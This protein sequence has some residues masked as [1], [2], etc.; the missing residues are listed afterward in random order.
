MKY[1]TNDKY[2]EQI[3]SEDKAYF[4]GLLF[5]DGYNFIGKSY[6]VTLQ[7]CIGDIDILK[8]FRSYIGDCTIYIYKNKNKNHQDI[9]RLQINSKKISTDLHNIGCVQGK[10]LILEFPDSVLIEPFMN[11]FIRGYFDGNGCVWE[12][13]RGKVLCKDISRKEGERIRIVHN[14][15]FNIVG[16]TN[17]IKGIQNILVSELGFGQTILNNGKKIRGYS[18]L[19]YSG[20]L[21]MKKFYDYLYNNATLYLERK[22][23]KFE[24]IIRANIQ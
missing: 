21:Q 20:R 4:L 10:S 19:E 3:D 22:K 23:R 12:G 7:L 8:Q 18:Q 15:K 2:F 9:A 6:M 24:T 16:A 14:V 1:N 11:H 17:F 13:K 5:A